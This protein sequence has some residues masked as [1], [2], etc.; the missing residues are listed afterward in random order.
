MD[1]HLN[2]FNIKTR[3]N[4]GYRIYYVVMD[5]GHTWDEFVRGADNAEDS[6]KYVLGPKWRIYFIHA[7]S[8]HAGRSN[9][10]EIHVEFN[11]KIFQIIPTSA[12]ENM[13]SRLLQEHVFHQV[14][15]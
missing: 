13:E 2:V 6:F 12:I 14:K 4:A 10:R 7:I 11:A 15:R 1:I 8:A 9:H 5:H 3:L